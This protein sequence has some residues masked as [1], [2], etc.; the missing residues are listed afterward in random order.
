[1]SRF[2]VGLWGEVAKV[3]R[4]KSFFQILAVVS[5]LYTSGSNPGVA[6]DK[7]IGFAEDVVLHVVLHEIGHALI[8]E[9]DLPVLG[10]EET[11][12][13]AFATHY[14]TYHLPERALDVLTARI[15]S[16][17]VEAGEVPRD[18]WPVKGEHNSDARRTFQTVAL[19]V[20]ADKDKYSSLGAQLGF[21]ES[22][23][24]NAVDYGSEIHRSWRRILQPL[25]MPK[26]MESTEARVR[27]DPG[28]ELV[29]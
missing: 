22:D 16:W 18:K 9:F 17:Q 25:M 24:K 1:V 2:L 29:V 15:S 28:D 14:L 26:G 10:N 3:K 19:A 21:S 12:A 4:L 13:D 5:L 20:A 23:L 6:S 11:M 27:L 8:R 7:A